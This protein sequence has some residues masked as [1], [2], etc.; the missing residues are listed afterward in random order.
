MPPIRRDARGETLQ[1]CIE[2]QDPRR[3]KQRACH[4]QRADQMRGETAR[5]VFEI[6]GRGGRTNENLLGVQ[7]KTGTR[8]S[9]P[10]LRNRVATLHALLGGR[11][12]NV[13]S[14]QR[15]G[16]RTKLA[17]ATRQV[18]HDSR[19]GEA[20]APG[21][22]DAMGTEPARPSPTSPRQRCAYPSTARR[23]IIGD[24]RDRRRATCPTRTTAAALRQQEGFEEREK[25]VTF[26][27]RPRRIDH[28]VSAASS[29]ADRSRCGAGISMG[30]RASPRDRAG[31]AT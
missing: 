22:E 11:R 29:L 3:A 13:A 31:A 5:F 27:K 4:R 23:P 8:R 26:E 1:G 16:F 28:A 7:T 10:R 17:S 21:R 18:R 25:A 12:R 15:C 19:G 20:S 30:P 2:H 6:G 9:S 14:L 24:L